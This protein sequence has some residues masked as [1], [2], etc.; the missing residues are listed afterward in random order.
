MH[1]GTDASPFLGVSPPGT[2]FRDLLQGIFCHV[3]FVAILFLLNC[4]YHGRHS[5]E[6]QPPKPPEGRQL[7][8][9][10]APVPPEEK[11]SLDLESCRLLFNEAGKMSS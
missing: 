10:K 7:R 6:M 3:V 4:C 8:Y 9:W 11:E 2:C 5:M 1:Q